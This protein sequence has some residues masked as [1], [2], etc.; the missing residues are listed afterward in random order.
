M[1]SVSTEVLHCAHHTNKE[2]EDRHKLKT[3]IFEVGTQPYLCPLSLWSPAPQGG[4]S[5]H[6]PACLPAMGRWDTHTASLQMPSWALRQ[7]LQKRGNITSLLDLRSAD[8]ERHGKVE[9]VQHTNRL[10]ATGGR[11]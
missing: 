8:R 1:C 9:K 10:Q 4:P 2:E 6:L 7:T 5:T 3:S 11:W